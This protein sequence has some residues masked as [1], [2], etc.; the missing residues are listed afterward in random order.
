MRH[1]YTGI[2]IFSLTFQNTLSRLDSVRERESD[3]SNWSTNTSF[4]RFVCFSIASYHV[5]TYRVYAFARRDSH[6]GASRHVTLHKICT[7][8]HNKWTRESFIKWSTNH[9]T[10]MNESSGWRRRRRGRVF[11]GVGGII[12]EN[13]WIIFENKYCMW[14]I[15]KNNES[16]RGGN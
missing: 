9:E 2:G 7:R 4:M 5:G 3:F 8:T 15:K 16:F 13:K 10:W 11:G 12:C 1:S 14:K 6:G